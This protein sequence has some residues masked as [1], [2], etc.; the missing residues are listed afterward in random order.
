MCLRRT[1]TPVEY[2]PHTALL[3]FLENLPA[4]PTRRTLRLFGVFGR[5]AARALSLPWLI[6]TQ[7]FGSKLRADNV[8]RDLPKTDPG[9]VPRGSLRDLPKTNP[10][11]VPSYGWDPSRFLDGAGTSLVAIASI[12]S[13]VL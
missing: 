12:S 13:G 5:S 4:P 2:A 11:R 9:R 3:L 7:V 8:P 10:G 6:P 1:T